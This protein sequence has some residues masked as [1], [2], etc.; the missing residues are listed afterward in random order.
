MF[1]KM[2]ILSGFQNIPLTSSRI[3]M[4]HSSYKSLGDVEGGVETIIDAL[5]DFVGPKGTV[6]LPT[7][8]F[9]EWTE[10]HYFDISETPSKM[11]IIGEIARN[12]K[13]AIR[14]PHPI[15]SFTAL[16]KE[17]V[18][19]AKCDDARAFGDNSVFGRFHRMN[20][21]I[22]S[23]GLPWNSTFSM[24]HYVEYQTGCNYRR[25]KHFSGI[26]VDRNGEPLVKTYTM[27][28][29]KDF[30]VITDIEKGM[31]DLFNK[32]VIKA[33]SVGKATVHYST[34]QDFFDHMSLIVKNN[35]EKLH[36]IKTHSQ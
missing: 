2:E 35:P 17:K 26:Y 33:T 13:D 14:T 34:A 29:R 12:R 6:L 3:I 16:G 22:I 9:T 15:Y 30:D 7:F 36:R 18:S 11:G 31:D 1:T 8:N 20:G 10:Q 4:V 32:G 21:V 25:T 23:I 27:H 28:V 5:L 24:H 19:F